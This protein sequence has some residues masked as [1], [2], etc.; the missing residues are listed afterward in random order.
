MNFLS[1]AHFTTFLICLWLIFF[2]LSKNPSSNQNRVSSLFIFTYSIWNFAYT[3]F[4]AAAS[5]NTAILWFNIASIGWCSFA[6]IGLWFSMVFG[7]KE[8]LL[9]KWYFYFFI[10]LIPAIL[11]YEQWS[12]YLVDNYIKQFYGWQVVWSASIWSWLF[13]IYYVSFMSASLGI[14]LNIIKKA[15]FEYEKKQAKVIIISGLIIF[16]L[17][18]ITDV[19]IPWLK[20][21]LLPPIGP[22]LILVWVEGMVY[23]IN[24]YKLMV[25]TSAYAAGDILSTMGDSL[26]LIDPEGKIIEVNNAVLKLLGYSR[27][28]L[29]YQPADL[30][31]SEETPLFKK[32]VLE[33]LFKEGLF[34][35]YKMSFRTKNGEEIPISFSWSMMKDKN[36]DFIGIV[37]VARDMRDIIRLHQKEREF[38]VEKARSEA[39]QERARELQEAYDKLKTAQT[40]LLQ[41]EKMAAVG[42]LAG[43]VANEINN[44]MGVILGFSQSIVKRIKEDESLYKPLKSIEREAM[45]CKKLVMDLLTFSRIG[46]SHFELININQA[47]DETLSLIEGQAKVKSI[48][49][50]KEYNTGLPDIMANKNQIQQVIVNLFN[51]S[52][53]AMPDGGR[54]TI[55]TKQAGE[56]IEFDISDTGIGMT[57]EV[58]RHIF[59]PFFTT[60]EVGKGT[61]LGLSLCYEIIQKHNGKIEAESEEGRGS[62]FRIILPGN[63]NS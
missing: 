3:F 61:G 34:K 54:I 48:E 58:R 14:W 30:L 8:S 43:G 52:A 33:K 42:Q 20:P 59:E 24:K 2:T 56:Q 38:I 62:N 55:A 28:E 60:K 7:K 27:D 32:I 6:S 18:T 44:P 26:L 12:G 37:G 11:I 57:E 10:A 25:I 5:K 16:T 1:L 21:N 35:D 4:H 36:G 22:I 40:M 13:Y 45:R 41:S 17:G 51:N 29:I 39:L 47:I 23:A 46:K 15:K 31:F 63:K 50:I 9:K 19:L 49:I 53:D